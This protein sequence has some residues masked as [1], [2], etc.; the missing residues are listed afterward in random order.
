M[1]IPRSAP[2]TVLPLS[3]TLSPTNCAFTATLKRFFASAQRPNHYPSATSPDT[4][5]WIAYP[6]PHVM[7]QFFDG[8]T[9]KLKYVE[10]VHATDDPNSTP[11]D[12]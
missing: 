11:L 5:R 3:A 7:F 9:G 6:K 12:H 4:H 2:V 10:T 1:P 8:M